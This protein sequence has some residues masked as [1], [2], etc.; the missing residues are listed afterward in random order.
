MPLCMRFSTCWSVAGPMVQMILVWVPVGG[1][2]LRREAKSVTNRHW[3]RAEADPRFPLLEAGDH[4]D[5][6]DVRTSAERV[7]EV[8][9]ENIIR[10]ESGRFRILQRHPKKGSIQHEMDR[11]WEE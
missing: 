5:K 2:T 8:I 9:E 11:Q 3:P 7:L 1:K 6:G 10:K 4:S